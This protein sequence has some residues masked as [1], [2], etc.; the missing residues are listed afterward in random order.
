MTELE[1]CSRI[2]NWALDFMQIARGLNDSAYQVQSS[3]CSE[4]FPEIRIGCDLIHNRSQIRLHV[5]C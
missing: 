2:S 1:K 4:E 3:F 5:I